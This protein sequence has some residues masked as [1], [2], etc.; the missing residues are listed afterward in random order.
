[1]ARLPRTVVAN[2][3]HHVT[4]RGNRREAIFFEDGDQEIYRDLLAEQTRKA[5]VEVWAYCLMPNHVHLILTFDV[6]PQAPVPVNASDAVQNWP[7]EKPNLGKS[8]LAHPPAESP[9]FKK[10]QKYQI[11]QMVEQAAPRQDWAT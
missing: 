11:L 9:N 1:M 10:T 5:E 3:P 7:T 8:D 4:Q 2:L 6:L